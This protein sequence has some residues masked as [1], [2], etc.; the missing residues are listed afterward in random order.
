MQLQKM[1]FNGQFKDMSHDETAEQAGNMRSQLVLLWAIML[2]ELSMVEFKLGLPSWHEC[3]GVTVE[4]FELAG[5]SPTDVAVM[6][7]NHCSNN[8]AM[9][10]LKHR[11]TT[12]SLVL[13][14]Q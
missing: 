9:E 10:G 1:G 8:N 6:V 5:V 13:Q 11:Y 3:L 14:Q 4:K 12:R 2:Y 7:K